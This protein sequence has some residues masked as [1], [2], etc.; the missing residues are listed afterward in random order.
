MPDNFHIAFP[1]ALTALPLPLL[2]YWI[3]PSL[4]MRSA[5]LLLPTY[6]K[7]VEYT[8]QKPRKSAFVKRRGFFSWLI[9]MMIWCLLVAAMV[10]PQLVGQPEMK[11]KTSR[12][13]LIVAD[14]SF[15]MAKDDWKIE[16]KKA[17]RWDAVKD[18]MHDF[19]KKRKGDRM[20]LVFFGTNAYI[21]A[22]FT[23]D[24]ETVDQMLEEA[25]VGMAG[26]MTHVGKAINKGLEMFENDTIK[27]KVMLLLTDGIDAGDGVLPLDA[28]D[29]ARKDSVMIYTLGIGTPG[30]GGSD[31][32]ERTLQQIAE[33]TGGHYFLA[34]DEERLKEIYTE[35]DKLEPMEYEEAQNKPITRLYPYPLGIALVIVLLSTLIAVLVSAIKVFRDRK[36]TYV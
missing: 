29:M 12:S 6:H 30:H 17:R 33:M 23:P 21:Q 14:I 15:S 7:A 34:K 4:H 28:A 24:L 20:G 10:N 25:D 11:I 36:E 3:L 31:L 9:L 1:W 26:Q 13:F 16:G 18:V 8:G 5:A 19:I 22:P 27:S 32:D 2:V 35:L